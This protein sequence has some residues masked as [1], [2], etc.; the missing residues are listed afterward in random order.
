MRILLTSSASH[1]PPRGGS[2]RSN[3][4][5]LAALAASGHACRVV[6]GALTPDTPEKM[7]LVRRELEDQEIGPLRR[8]RFMRW[9]T[10]SGEP[11]FFRSRFGSFN[12]IGCW[13]LPKTSA[14]ACCAPRTKPLPAALSTWRTL[15][16]SIR[17]ARRVGIPTA[18]A[19]LW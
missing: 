17:S 2:T 16:S 4:A 6:G 19:R 8:P 1:V 13:F 12:P 9:P 7:T 15:R 10:R 5:W 18:R 11:P 3:L 14:K